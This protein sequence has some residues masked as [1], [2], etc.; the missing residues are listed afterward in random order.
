MI[1]LSQKEQLILMEINKLEINKPITQSNLARKLS[2]MV[3]N[4]C[5]LNVWKCMIDEEAL[6]FE[7]EEGRNIKYKID[8]VKLW[9]MIRETDNFK[10]IGKLI[11]LNVTGFR[12]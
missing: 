12:Y 10:L 9:N 11:E 5:F 8:N 7:C 3:C 4:S 2:I 1:T 6:K